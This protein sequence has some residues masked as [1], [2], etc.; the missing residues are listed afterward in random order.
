MAGKAAYPLKLEMQGGRQRL[1]IGI[2][3]YLAKVSATVEIDLDVPDT[4]AG[5]APPDAAP[6]PPAPAESPVGAAD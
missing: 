1:A 5:I 4:M 2:R 6:E 3:D